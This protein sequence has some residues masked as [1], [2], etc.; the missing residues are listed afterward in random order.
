MPLPALPDPAPLPRT[1]GPAHRAGVPLSRPVRIAGAVVLAAS[2]VVF[3]LTVVVRPDGPVYLLDLDVYRGGARLVLDGGDLYGT[4]VPV[5][6]GTLPFTYPP[7]AALVFIPLALLPQAVASLAVTV[8]TCLGLAVTVHALARE[9]GTTLP[10]R[11]VAVV[12]VL[13]LPVLVWFHPVLQTFGFGQVNVVLMAVVAV[14][15]LLP[16]TPW[17]RGALI[18]LA[19]AVKLTP[20]VFVLV[21]LLRRR[22]R[23][24][25]VAVGTGLG[26][27]ALVWL[28]L[29][30][31]STAYWFGALRDPGRIGRLEYASNQSL[32]GVVARTVSGGDDVQSVVWVVASLVVAVLVV[33]AMVR[34]LR[35]GAVTAA[36]VANALLALLVSP[37][38]WSH[39]WVWV[40][41]M[42]L[43]TGAAAVA[44][45]GAVPVVLGCVVALVATVAPVHVFLPSDDG[46]ERTWPPL[47][48]ILGSE[49]P[50]V[51]IAWLVAA[52]AAPRAFLPGPRRAAPAGPASGAPES[53]GPATG[54]PTSE[55]L[56]AETPH[57]RRTVAETDT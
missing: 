15:L 5:R 18:G 51:G 17:P 41:P 27:S 7:L 31:D 54:E 23:A 55:E 1:P 48:M 56:P 42:L 40:V 52:V 28:V 4:P 8:V 39:H 25:A 14:D 11:D 32:R 33:A 50:L 35:R 2:T 26:A 3:I 9:A 37:V 57:A 10:R 53:T 38:S 34:L 44:G 43:V 22:W 49:Y 13:A 12:S 36:V 45:R 30:A 16:R 29:P 20:A 24:A 6:F 46:V 19:A 21:L 47:L